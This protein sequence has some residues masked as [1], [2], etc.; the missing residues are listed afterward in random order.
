MPPIPPSGPNQPPQPAPL[1]PRTRQ[2][3]L[4]ALLGS[5]ERSIATLVDKQRALREQGAPDE[6][7]RVLR[8]KQE[9]RI[10][11]FLLGGGDPG[12][13]ATTLAKGDSTTGKALLEC[14]SKTRTI[15]QDMLENASSE[16]SKSGG[17]K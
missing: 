4:A 3:E 6:T 2:Q 14:L 7:I 8:E 16:E 1:L 5:V 10:F 17:P 11:A 12:S 9:A 15:L 13:L